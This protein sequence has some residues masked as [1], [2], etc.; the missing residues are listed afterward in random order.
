MFL[1][2]SCQPAADKPNELEVEHGQLTGIPS[3]DAITRDIEN[4]PNNLALYV[5]RC[6]A[7]SSEGMLKE[8]EEEA[9]KIWERDKTNWRSARLLAWAYFDN[10]KSK[11]AIKVL[12]QTLEIHPDTTHLLLLHAQMNMLV[13]QYDEA[14]I[15]AEN[16]LK[17]E[18]FNT[19]GLF[20]KGLTLKYMGDTIGALG[21][22]QTA[23]EL[24]AD[25]SDAYMQLATIFA[26][27]KEKIALQYYDNV[28]RIDSTS[29]EGLFGKAQFYHQN[30]T[31]DNG[32]LALAK[33]A[34]ENTII[35]HPQVPEAAF[36]YAMLYMEE[37]DYV[38]AHHFFDVATK[39]DPTFGDAYYFK[40]VASEKMGD[41]K[42]AL[43]DYRNAASNNDRF[44]RAA[45]ALK[46]LK[47]NGAS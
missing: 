16:V 18:P 44:G 46:R 38:Q 43:I 47:E 29:Y 37:R 30:Y 34:Y 21:N 4:D 42:S 8:A 45:A 35:N 40:G 9:R 13:E 36:N 22:F 33:E 26:H 1:L 11:P 20:M 17:L 27:N 3:I 32:M 10:N 7:Y 15:S 5:A 14:L 2:F 19:E 24:D 6:E 25:F 31:V 23:I 39:Y 41:T 12:N 28:L